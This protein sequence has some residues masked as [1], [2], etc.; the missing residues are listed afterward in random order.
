MSYTPNVPQATQTIAFTQPLIEANFTYID[1]AMK[2]DHAWNGNEI[3]GQA[4][5]S[6]QKISLPNQP[7]DITGALPTGIADIIYAIGG[8]IF[9]WDGTS[10]NPI[11]AQWKEG[12][13]AIFTST[14]VTVLAMPANCI[15]YVMI[16]EAPISANAAIAYPFLSFGGN[17]YCFNVSH[18]SN[19]KASAAVIGTNLVIANITGTNYACAWKLIYWP[20]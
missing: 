15:G 1:T 20:I 16:T 7:V 9:A 13:V 11:S 5:G 17:Y 18:Y 14:P 19:V 10:K 2:V 4:D 6:H 12:I 8:N 3:A